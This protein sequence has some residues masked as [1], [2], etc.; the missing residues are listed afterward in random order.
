MTSILDLINFKGFI[1]E[2]ISGKKRKMKEKMAYVA[3][4]KHQK[5]DNPTIHSDVCGPFSTTCMA[6]HW[7]YVIFVNDFS[8]KCWI[9]F[10]QKKNLTFAKFCEFKALV[11]KD[12]SRKVKTLR[13][14]DNGEYV[15][16]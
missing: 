11:E 16:N 1:D 5:S 3:K 14:D 7:Y 12:T 2:N 13:S 8:H 15:S 4:I 10:M 9:F 6:K